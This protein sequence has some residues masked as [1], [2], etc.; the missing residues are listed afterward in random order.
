MHLQNVA[1]IIQFPVGHFLP[2]H[3]PFYT[4]P[5]RLRGTLVLL[6]LISECLQ[7]LGFLCPIGVCLLSCPI[8]P[9]ITDGTRKSQGILS[10]ISVCLDPHVH[11]VLLSRWDNE[12]PRSCVSSVYALIPM[13]I[14]SRCPSE[15]RNSLGILCLICLCFCFGAHVHSIP[16]SQWDR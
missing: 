11:L 9:H 2:G 15:T 7:S 16:L 3:L 10:S 8:V 12:F 4:P 14:L 5:P 6:Y 1:I 13:S